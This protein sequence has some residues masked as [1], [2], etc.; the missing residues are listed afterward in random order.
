MT[1]STEPTIPQDV[2]GFIKRTLPNN[3]LI[4]DSEKPQETKVIEPVIEEKR[5]RGRPKKV[6]VEAKS[7]NDND[8]GLKRKRGRRKKPDTIIMPPPMTMT[9]SRIESNY[10]VMLDIKYSDLDI[11]VSGD[12]QTNSV[13]IGQDTHASRSKISE[14]G[15]RLICDS[16]INSFSKLISDRKKLYDGCPTLKTIHGKLITPESSPVNFYSN[17]EQ[18]QINTKVLPIFELNGNDWPHYSNYACWNCDCQFETPPIGMP[19]HISN[20]QFYCSGNFC[21]FPCTARFIIDNDNTVNRFE[22]ISLLN[23]LYQMAYNLDLDAHVSVANPRQ[24]LHKYGGCLSYAQYH[25]EKAKEVHLYKLPIVPLYYY[26]CHET[27]SNNETASECTA[28]T[29]GT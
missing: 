17:Y 25:G 18:Q 16:L 1:A 13:A 21:S 3:D 7:P 4:I 8:F 19:E 2:N 10:I 11:G 14:H 5:K 12:V 22:K 15:E 23:T 6:S 28:L 26:L 9:N 27:A 20:N 24:T 29:T